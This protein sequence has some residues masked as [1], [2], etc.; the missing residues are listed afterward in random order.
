MLRMSMMMS[1]PEPENI[2]DEGLASECRNSDQIE[3]IVDEASG[4]TDSSDN[5]QKTNNVL[6]LRRRMGIPASWPK[7][8]QDL[9]VREL[10]SYVMTSCGQDCLLT[11]SDYDSLNLWDNMVT[12]KILFSHLL[13]SG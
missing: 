4:C 7:K 5:L 11:M 9:K 3:D 10:R 8:Q 13:S 2:I 6:S 1:P 12:S